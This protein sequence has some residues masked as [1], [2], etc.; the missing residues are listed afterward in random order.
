VAAATSALKVLVM[1]AFPRDAAAAHFAYKKALEWPYG[2]SLIE[3]WRK[4]CTAT[5]TFRNLYWVT[6]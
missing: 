1:G 5:R 4:G 6:D 2:A 3:M